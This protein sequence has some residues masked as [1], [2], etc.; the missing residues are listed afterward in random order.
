MLLHLF[1]VVVNCNYAEAERINKGYKSAE[2]EKVLDIEGGKPM[3]MTFKV[4]IPTE[5]YPNVSIFHK[6][7]L[8]SR[9]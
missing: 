9:I 5:K 3:R 8:L 4:T 2:E 7:T 1:K 6:S